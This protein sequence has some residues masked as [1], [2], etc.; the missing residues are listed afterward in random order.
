MNFM[1]AIE[2]LKRQNEDKFLKIQCEY[3]SDNP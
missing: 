1:K 2:I 3:P